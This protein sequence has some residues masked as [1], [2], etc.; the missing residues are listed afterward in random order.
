MRSHQITIAELSDEMLQ[1]R[2]NKKEFVE[3]IDALIPWDEW[4][5][6]IEPVL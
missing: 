5:R 2:T 3:K 6:I 4:V 1:A